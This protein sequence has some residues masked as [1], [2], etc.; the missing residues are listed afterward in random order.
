MISEHLKTLAKE[1]H[2]NF[3]PVL[4]EVLELKLKAH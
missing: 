4:I 2:I 3:L 1:I